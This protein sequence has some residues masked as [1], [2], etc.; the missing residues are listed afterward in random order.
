MN[1]WLLNHYAS[2]PDRPAGTRHY[3][4]GRVLVSRGHNVT[5]FASSFSHHSLREERLSGR[6]WIQIEFVDGVRFVWIRTVPY[7]RNDHRRI[8][9]ILSYSLLVIAAQQRFAR[10][11]VVV[12][13]SVHLGA[14]AAAWVI[15]RARRAAFIFEVRDLWPQA[16]IDMGELRERSGAARAL[17]RL[18]RFLY[19]RARIIISLLPGV[20]PYISSLG[21]PAEKIVYIPNGFA[22]SPAQPAGAGQPGAELL[23]RIET[24]RQAG[25]LIAGYAG[26]HGLANGV[27]ILVEAA[28]VL[29]ERKVDDVAFIFIGDGPAK[30]KCEQIAKDHNLEN[31]FFCPPLPKRVIPTVL[32]RLD[33]ALFPLRDPSV[34]RYGLSS[35]KIFDYL[36]SGR[37]I[38][39]C[40]GV[41]GNPIETSGG[42]MSVPPESPEAVADALVQFAE[43]SD[44]D[45]RAM[46]EQGR[47][48]VYENHEV[49]T[50][51]VR[52]L[53]ALSEVQQ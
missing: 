12:G 6:R 23:A 50:L 8:L 20:I 25:Y 47:R 10:P 51:A 44:E 30:G 29:R 9:N 11:D 48:W 46:G 52:F 13:S 3:D 2:P 22:D 35:N 1:I 28:R 53:Q 49:T 16:L 43:M 17:R 34:A 45:R 5:I 40:C 41:A 31:V 4:F 37:P 42:G 27:D 24:W 32:R 33:V 36:A 18:E 38:V 7:K 39:C 15:G 14:V 19:Q 21:I 26:S